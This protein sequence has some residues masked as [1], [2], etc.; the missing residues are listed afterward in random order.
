MSSRRNGLEPL[1]VRGE[2]DR[3][4]LLESP[5][6]ISW[7]W[8][9]R[10]EHNISDHVV[11]NRSKLTAQAEERLHEEED[12]HDRTEYVSEHLDS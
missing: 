1:L 10:V 5:Q 2:M 8:A 7:D 11:H 12:A 4:E 3:L 6:N 9:R